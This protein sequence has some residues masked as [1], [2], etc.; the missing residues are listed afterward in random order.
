MTMKHRA[1][2]LSATRQRGA[3]LVISLLLLLVMTLLGLGASQSTRLQERM[4]GNQRDQELALQGAEAALRDA[5]DDL[6]PNRRPSLSMCVATGTT[7]CQSYPKSFFVDAVTT[8]EVDLAKQTDEWWEEYGKVN[9]DFEEQM[10]ELAAL[11]EYVV[12]YVATVRDVLSESN[13]SPQIE[14]EFYRVTARSTGL[15][16][17]AEVVLQ[18]TYARK[19][20]R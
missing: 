1:S 7:T 11:P 17:S 19:T 18:T 4:A 3:A 20:F 8:M 16:E 12:E 9:E 13:P 10:P 14:R 15:T 5:E 6:D 2:R